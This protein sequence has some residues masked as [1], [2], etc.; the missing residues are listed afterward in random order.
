MQRSKRLLV[1]VAAAAVAIGAGAALI[2][3]GTRGHTQPRFEEHLPHSPNPTLRPATS[4]ADLAKVLCQVAVP[5][6]LF[7]SEPT[8]VGT[9]RDTTTGGTQ[10]PSQDTLYPSFHADSFGAWC[11]SGR[12]PYDV[13]EVTADGKAHLVASRTVVPAKQA[14]GA[15]SARADNCRSVPFAGRLLIGH[16]GRVGWNGNRR[17]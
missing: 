12:G 4:R 9:F 2:Y 11:W 16:S 14:H 13:Y 10:V 5:A 15:P 1:G 3:V 17:C 6:P 8:T 7:S